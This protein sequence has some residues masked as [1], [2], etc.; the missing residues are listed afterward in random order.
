MLDQV[1]PDQPVASSAA[2]AAAAA[3]ASSVPAAAAAAA[4]S[5]SA[6]EPVSFLRTSNSQLQPD[7]TFEHADA[8][9]VLDFF[10][11]CASCLLL[12]AG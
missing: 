8:D 5:S 1:A 2:A 9:S 4:A 11:L 6:E 7:K 12:A 10:S 3:A